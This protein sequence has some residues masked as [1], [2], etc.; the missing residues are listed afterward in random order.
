MGLRGMFGVEVGPKG[1]VGEGQGQLVHSMEPVWR[2]V[3]ILA[4][5]A[6]IPS[7]GL[8]YFYFN[9]HTCANNLLYMC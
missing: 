5:R 4:Q 2:E 6:I 3:H 9:C 7:K 1:L 8:F